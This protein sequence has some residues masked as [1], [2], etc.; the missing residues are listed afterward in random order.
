MRCAALFHRTFA[1]DLPERVRMC[2]VCVNPQNIRKTE[3]QTLH[4]TVI[5][6]NAQPRLALAE[7][8]VDANR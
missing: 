4:T 2:A 6:M 7:S 5:K 8:G 3:K 1:Q